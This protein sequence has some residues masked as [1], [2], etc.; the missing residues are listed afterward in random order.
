MLSPKR[1]QWRSFPS[2]LP[3]PDPERPLGGLGCL[4][5]LTPLLSLL[6][7]RA[8]PALCP[9]LINFLPSGM[10]NTNLKKKKISRI[11]KG[12]ATVPPPFSQSISSG[13]LVL[14]NSSLPL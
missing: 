2:P 4:S 5:C 10:A 3:R 8:G 11:E 7:T 6:G 1:S 9:N 12:K 14:I 13:K